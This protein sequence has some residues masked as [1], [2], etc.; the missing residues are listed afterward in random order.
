[1]HPSQKERAIGEVRSLPK[2]GMWLQHLSWHCIECA[3][4]HERDTREEQHPWC[5]QGIM[6][7]MI[8]IVDCQ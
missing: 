5:E 2:G 6:R 4:H 3:I 1:V 7:R 8:S